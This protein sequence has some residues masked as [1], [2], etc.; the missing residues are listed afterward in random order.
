MAEFDI[1]DLF[2]RGGVFSDIEAET[3]IAVY[4]QVCPKMHL[5]ASVTCE[6]FL[7]GLCEREKIMSTAVGRGIAIPHCRGTILKNDNE[8]QIAVCYLK[9]PIDMNAPDG[10]KVAVM[11]V[12]LTSNSQTHLQVLSRLAELFKND[13]FVAMLNRHAS[14]EELAEAARN[15]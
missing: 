4:E 6:S 15:F 8:Q 11:F 7:T 13:G 14:A 2:I 3:P 5:P 12:L 9:H 10:R 1:G